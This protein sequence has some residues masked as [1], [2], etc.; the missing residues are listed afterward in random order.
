MSEK[1]FNVRDNIKI[2]V[3]GENAHKGTL[4]IGARFLNAYYTVEMT[5]ELFESNGKEIIKDNFI[6]IIQ[7]HIDKMHSDSDFE[8]V[9]KF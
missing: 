4:D 9:D 8:F 2:E 5:P 1:D 7:K 6:P 3:L